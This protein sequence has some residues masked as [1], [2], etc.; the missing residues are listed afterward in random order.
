MNQINNDK[1]FTENLR[2]TKHNA[3]AKEVFLKLLLSRKNQS[4][5]IWRN[6]IRDFPS[7]RNQAR[8]R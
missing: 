7:K 2:D 5:S 3:K 8:S 6:Q 1:S 4:Q